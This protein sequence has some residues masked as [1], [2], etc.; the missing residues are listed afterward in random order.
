LL[1]NRHAFSLAFLMGGLPILFVFRDFL[2]FDKQ[3]FTYAIV[4]GVLVALPKYKNIINL[5]VFTNGF[6]VSIYFLFSMSI[7]IFLISF[8]ENRFS[9]QTI[10]I[11]IIIYLIFS[12][13]TLEKKD[14]IY[15]ID[16]MFFI[17]SFSVIISFIFTPTSIE[18]WL[19]RGGR[20]YVGDTNNPDLISWVSCIVII[21]AVFYFYKYKRISMFVKLYMLSSIIVA[22]YL[23][24]LSFSKS[25]ILSIVMIILF[26]ALKKRK[27]FFNWKTT[28][29]L[30]IIV[31]SFFVYLPDKI[32]TIINAINSLIGNNTTNMSASI[33]YENF[34][35]AFELFSITNF[36]G[37]GINT[38]RMDSPILQMSLDL[39]IIISFFMLY[40]FFLYPMF[41][42]FYYKIKNL[43]EN[44]LFSILLYLFFLP[45]LFFHGTPYE[46]DT[47]LPVVLFYA[48]NKSQLIFKVGKQ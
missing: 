47:W 27:I 34:K 43:S 39:G 44:E 26:L 17:S 29:V 36:F 20:F 14:Y 2:P 37:Y 24:I 46:W 5:K 30:I 40:L 45:N 18:Y 23:W 28:L 7:I 31:I 32:D 35:K 16:Y 15:F 25:S 13:V 21:S 1:K 9:H 6:N 10:S 8:I 38:F 19:I 4:F 22:V 3:T 33:R 11:G 12:L 48:I 42:I 41:N